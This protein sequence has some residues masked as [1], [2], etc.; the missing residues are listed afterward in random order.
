MDAVSVNT[1]PGGALHVVLRGEIDFTNSAWVRKVICDAVAEQRPPA[2]RVEMAEVAFLDSSGIGML[3]D[4]MRAA[5]EAD[6]AFRVEHPT[7][8]VY[9]QLRTAGLLAAFGLP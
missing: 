4:V 5:G 8:R 3:V 1:V 6:A 9:D 2:V 7:S